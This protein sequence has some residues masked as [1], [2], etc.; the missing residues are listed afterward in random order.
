M[1]NIDNDEILNIDNN[2]ISPDTY[3]F[4]FF[5]SIIH[6]RPI[7]EIIPVSKN[8]VDSEYAKYIC[9]KYQIT[10]IELINYKPTDKERF[11]R[12]MSLYKRGK[13]YDKF[14]KLDRSKNIYTFHDNRYGK[15]VYIY[16]S[17]DRAFC[18]DMFTYS[19]PKFK[20]FNNGYSCVQ[21]EWFDN[22]QLKEQYYH[23]NGIIEGPYEQYNENGK[24]IHTCTY[25]KASEAPLKLRQSHINFVHLDGIQ[26]K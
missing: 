16:K 3:Y 10:N 2:E 22:G 15:P 7:G 11:K 9:N 17:F 8:I 24:L 5:N 19:N 25:I 14:L 18:N 6:I 13:T 4:D 23:N 12:Y 1:E 21:K 26:K 20:Y